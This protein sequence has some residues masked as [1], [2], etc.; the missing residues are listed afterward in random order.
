MKLT[1]LGTGT[2][3]GIPVIACDCRVCTSTDPKDGRHRCSVFIQD[4]KSDLNLLIDAGPEFRIQALKYKIKKIDTVL[5][6]HSHADHLHGADDLRIFSCTR[7]ACAG[8]PS[9]TIPVHIYGNDQTL[10]DFKSRFNYMFISHE[11]GG[12]VAHVDLNS[13]APYSTQNPLVIKG[14]QIVPVDLEHGPTL[15]TG[16]IFNKK[17]AYLTDVSHIPNHSYKRIEHNS[18]LEHLIIDGLRPRPHSTH[19]NFDQALE[20]AEKIGAKHTWFTHI[21]HDSSHDD[22]TEYIQSRLSKYPKLSEIVKAGGSVAPAFD[23][24]EIEF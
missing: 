14:L 7:P 13:M 16:Y 24:M 1:F 17:L 6:T 5:L 8:K 4:E 2:S 21:C 12:G 20:A 9:S 18:P 22:V 3:H 23:G 10:Q 19:F 15:C 11:K